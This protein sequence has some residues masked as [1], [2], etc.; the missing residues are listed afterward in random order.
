[1]Y[2]NQPTNYAI[3]KNSS[4]S[5]ICVTVSNLFACKHF[6]GILNR[7]LQQ[8]DFK[9]TGCTYLNLTLAQI[10]LGSTKFK[11]QLRFATLRS[12]RLIAPTPL[13]FVF[14]EVVLWPL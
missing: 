2:D 3:S 10:I 1:M 13:T 12:A 9:K 7:E 5:G 8:H 11:E 6:I 4:L 14:V